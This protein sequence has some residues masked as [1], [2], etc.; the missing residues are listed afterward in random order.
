[1]QT[2]EQVKARMTVEPPA[3]TIKYTCKDVYDLAQFLIQ[4]GKAIHGVQIQ[5][6]QAQETVISQIKEIQT[7]LEE[8]KTESWKTEEMEE[9]E[10]EPSDE[11]DGPAICSGVPGQND[12]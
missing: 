8:E 10:D 11:E 12:V 5:I 9:E 2:L 7:I 6:L 3:K 4:Q 1:M